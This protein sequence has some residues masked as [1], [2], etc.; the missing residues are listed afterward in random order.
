MRHLKRKKILAQEQAGFRQFRST[1]DQTTYLAQEIEDAFQNKNVLFATWIDLQKAFDKVWTDGLLVKTLKCGVG[2]KMY[3]WIYYFLQN[4]KA[5][6]LVDGKQYGKFIFKHGV[7]QGGVFSP[8]LFHIYTN[9]LMDNLP[10]AIKVALYEDDLVMWS[11]EEYATTATHRMQTSVTALAAW[12]SGMSRST[13]RNHP[14]HC[15]P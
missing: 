10:R 11:T 12:G 4:R 2:G 6:V 14:L 15:S 9:D 5:S 8:T 13:K 7:P 3:R 1:E